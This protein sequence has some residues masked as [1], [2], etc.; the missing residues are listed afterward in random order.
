MKAVL[1]GHQF[2][3]VVKWSVFK[4]RGL[5][6]FR[7]KSRQVTIFSHKINELS[8]ATINAKT[9]LIMRFNNAIKCE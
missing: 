2:S 8:I 5:G 9:K 3:T 1:P 7:F 6:R 4:G